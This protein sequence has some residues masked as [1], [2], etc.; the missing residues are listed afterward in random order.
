MGQTELTITVPNTPLRF[1]SECTF[2][3]EEG[4]ISVEAINGIHYN[5][6]FLSFG[7]VETSIETIV[8]GRL[9]RSEHCKITKELLDNK[10]GYKTDAVLKAVNRR[11]AVRIPCH[12][13][14]IVH[15]GANRG[16]YNGTTCDI[17][18][19][20]IGV[21]AKTEDVETAREGDECDINIVYKSRIVKVVGILMRKKNKD[22]GYTSMGFM[23]KN[24]S[25]AYTNF[26][27]EIQRR[28]MKAK[29]ED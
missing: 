5:N 29:Q 26:V 4:T 25:I 7:D 21:Y 16:C 3:E 10:W 17:S 12:E 23:V 11:G 27:M 20:G 24:P 2:N 15:K 8:D 22:N 19:T 9:Y 28:A 13:D 6:K 18:L 1:T 14:V